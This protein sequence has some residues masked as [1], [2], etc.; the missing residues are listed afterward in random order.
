[1]GYIDEESLQYGVKRKEK[2]MTHL[3]SVNWVAGTRAV[4]SSSRIEFG[5]NPHLIRTDRVKLSS[6]RCQPRGELD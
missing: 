5:L 3:S 4:H 1:M 6:T 2:K